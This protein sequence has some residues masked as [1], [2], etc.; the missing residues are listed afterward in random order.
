MAYAGIL[1]RH[2][3]LDIRCWAD[4]NKRN[5]SGF[6]HPTQYLNNFSSE[7]FRGAALIRRCNI[8]FN[9][10]Q[11]PNCKLLLGVDCSLSSWYLDYPL[12]THQHHE[13]IIDYTSERELSD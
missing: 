8:Q 12:L 2:K 9:F 4:N 10:V 1:N 11:Q 13:G 5:K 7:L 3:Q 6:L